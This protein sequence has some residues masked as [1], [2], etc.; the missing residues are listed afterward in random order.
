MDGKNFKIWVR[1]ATVIGYLI[2]VCMPAVALSIYYI[3]FWN[4]QYDAKFLSKNASE[5]VNTSQSKQQV[6]NQKIVDKR[7]ATFTTDKIDR[8]LV[9]IDHKQSTADGKQCS[10]TI[11]EKPKAIGDSS[12][13]ELSAEIVDKKELFHSSL[14]SLNE[15]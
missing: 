11:E 8:I 1:L 9:N 14:G 7:D 6:S 13:E 15:K 4:P 5:L 2:S 3:G 12:M 10:C